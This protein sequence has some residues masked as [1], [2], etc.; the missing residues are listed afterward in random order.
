MGRN[1]FSFDGGDR[2]TAMGA[3]RFVSYCYYI[4]IVSNYSNW[5]N[6]QTAQNRIRVF[7][8]TKDYHKF[9]LSEVLKMNNNNLEKIL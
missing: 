3:C 2:L 6:V 4:Q 8:T 1:V 9:W 5:E 7:S